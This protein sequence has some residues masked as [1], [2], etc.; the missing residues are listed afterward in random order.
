MQQ[1]LANFNNHDAFMTLFVLCIL[2]VYFHNEKS[3][4]I[5]LSKKSTIY[6]RSNIKGD[7]DFM[8][9]KQ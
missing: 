9:L 2:E 7:Q 4:W 8:R 3:K 6:I 5:L 1:F